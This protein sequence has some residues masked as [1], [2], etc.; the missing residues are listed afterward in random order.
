MALPLIT[1]V[2]LNVTDA[3]CLACRYCFVSQHPNYMSYET[4][5][6]T[7][8]FLI[9][10]AEQSG[11]IPSINFFGGEPTLCWDSVIVPLTRYIRET[12]KRPFRLSMTTN[13]VLLNAERIAFMKNNQISILFSIDGDRETQD[14]NRPCSDGNGSFELLEK[15]ID[16]I[17]QSFPDVT[18]RS[19]IIPE[20][21]HNIF[22]NIQFALKHGFKHF[23]IT[24]NTF[25]RWQEKDRQTVEKELR[26][27]SDWVI[28]YFRSGKTPPISFSEYDRAFVKIQRINTAIARHQYR[29]ESGCHSCGKCGLGATRFAAVDYK[30]DVLGCQE[31]ASQAPN[32]RD[33]FFIGNIYT[34]IDDSR[35]EALMGAYHS[36]AEHGTDCKNCRLARICDGGCAANNY[37]INGDVNICP[38]TYCWWVRLILDEAIYIM[39]TLGKEENQTFSLYW[40]MVHD[41]G[42][43]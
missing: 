40:R 4:A 27:Y 7:A 39:H 2:F 33:M 37:M 16:L 43:F 32:V 38:P 17:A 14:Y 20:T 36:K 5:K 29:T 31:L 3:C 10:N 35:R 23:F 25:E 6:D 26:K 11:D 42:K 12:Y 9:R 28:S 21:C 13:G 30:G 8:D 34:G 1:S 24:P 18:F 22:H 41:G 19:T 15:N